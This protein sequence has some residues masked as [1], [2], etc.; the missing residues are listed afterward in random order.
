M[1]I[2]ISGTPDEVLDFCKKI[3]SNQSTKYYKLK[4]GALLPES[5]KFSIS[6]EVR[7]VTGLGLKEAKEAVE[8]APS[9]I[10]REL[11]FEDAKN[12][13]V[14]IISAATGVPVRIV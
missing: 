6:K 9:I 8:S 14:D 10:D 11:L 3:S 13:P 4:L 12:I 2:I 5:L 7:L 1:E